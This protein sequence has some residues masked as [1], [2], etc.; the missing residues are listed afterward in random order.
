MRWEDRITVDAEI[1]AGKP[2][3]RGT[4]MAVEFIVELYAEGWSR[5][6]ILANYPQLAPEDLQAALTYASERIKS[7]VLYPLPA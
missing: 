5:E 2:I 6:Q 4:R 7:E 1:L 3:I